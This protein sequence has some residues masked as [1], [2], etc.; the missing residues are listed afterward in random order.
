MPS[1]VMIDAPLAG[2]TYRFLAIE[3]TL[4]SGNFRVR[5]LGWK[6]GT[7]WH[8]LTGMTSANTP[9]PQVVVATSHNTYAP[10][11]A[12][13]RIVDLASTGSHWNTN[14]TGNKQIVLDLGAGNGIAPE[15]LR[16]MCYSASAQLMEAFSCYGSNDTAIMTIAN[17][18]TA[19]KTLLGTFTP[20][21]T[22][23]TVGVYREFPFT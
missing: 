16:I 12:Y 21:L 7:D 14:N 5:E 13:D 4:P 19:S 10:W 17:W 22:G 3:T 23:W 2:T 6:V 1:F 18:A 8:P 15:G 9:V 20:G 11:R